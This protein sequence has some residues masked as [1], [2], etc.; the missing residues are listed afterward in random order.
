M[1]VT[2]LTGCDT[3]DEWWYTASGV[4]FMDEFISQG[5]DHT[6]SQTPDL[7]HGSICLQLR[8]KQNSYS[9][10]NL[11]IH[12]RL[13]KKTLET[14][15]SWHNYT[16]GKKDFEKVSYFKNHQPRRLGFVIGS[17]RTNLFQKIHIVSEKWSSLLAIEYLTRM[18][19]HPWSSILDI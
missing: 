3:L 17:D 4:C 16:F 1:N 12:F 11:F 18:K 19:D 5:S 13:L 8:K 7:V 2:L 14:S 15:L 9:F 6:V 10:G